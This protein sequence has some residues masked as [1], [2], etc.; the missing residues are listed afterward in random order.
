[1][2]S[3][4]SHAVVGCTDLE[5]TAHFL[6]HFDVLSEPAAGLSAGAAAALYGL[7][8]PT[9]Q[10][11]VDGSDHPVRSGL[12]LS[13]AVRRVMG[14]QRNGPSTATAWSGWIPRLRINRSRVRRGM[15]RSTSSRRTVSRRR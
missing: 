11:S 8:G 10:R 3:S 4:P 13:C 14:G 7:D 9:V 1:M 12:K 5:T 2:L 6:A 15:P